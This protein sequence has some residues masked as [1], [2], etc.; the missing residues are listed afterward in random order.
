MSSQNDLKCLGNGKLSK[1]G[2]IIDLMTQKV[3]V[4]KESVKT[5]KF[6]TQRLYRS[7]TVNSKS[8]VGKVFPS[9]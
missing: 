3:D 2:V 4:V 9:N 8:F 5:A 6:L 1:A 7:G